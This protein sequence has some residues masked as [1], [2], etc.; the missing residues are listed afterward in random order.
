MAAAL[1]ALQES[2]RGHLLAQVVVG[3]GHQPVVAVDQRDEGQRLLQEVE[4]QLLDWLDRQ[5]K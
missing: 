4:L 5:G 2:G 1:Q 3:I